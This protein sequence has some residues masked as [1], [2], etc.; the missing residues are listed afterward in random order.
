MF[1]DKNINHKFKKFIKIAKINVNN[2]VKANELKMK[3][4]NNKIFSLSK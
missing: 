1:D 3:Y 2:P 4:N